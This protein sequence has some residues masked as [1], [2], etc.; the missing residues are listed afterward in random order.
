MLGSRGSVHSLLMISGGAVV[1]LLGQFPVLLPH[2]L[3]VT[4][5]ASSMRWPVGCDRGHRSGGRFASYR[6]ISYAARSEAPQS[7]IEWMQAFH[8]VPAPGSKRAWPMPVAAA[9]RSSRRG[10]CCTGSLVQPQGAPRRTA[11]RDGRGTGACRGNEAAPARDPRL[12]WQRL[13]GGIT[14]A[15]QAG[16][17][18][19]GKGFRVAGTPDTR[20][21]RPVRRSTSNAWPRLPPFSPSFQQQDLGCTRS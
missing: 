18:L 17:I 6:R 13:V 9:T 10:R 14:Q 19:Q 4:T 5:A 8:S 2:G 7:M 1:A 20:S 15:L 21:Q 11:G 3:S 16:E 12:R